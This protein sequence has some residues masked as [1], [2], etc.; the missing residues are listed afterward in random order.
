[1]YFWF[2]M[3]PNKNVFHGIRK[4]VEHLGQ[5]VIFVGPGSCLTERTYRDEDDIFF[6]LVDFCRF[7]QCFC[8]ELL[9]IGENVPQQC[10]KCFVLPVSS[11][12]YITLRQILCFQP[13][14]IMR[15]R[16]C[17]KTY[18][19]AHDV[20]KNLFCFFSQSPVQS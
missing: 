1:M 14:I 13:F 5:R 19:V 3:R 12:P 7:I 2:L 16:P 17:K 8:G 20:S 11:L 4:S 18:I 15:M 10:R 6:G 9:A